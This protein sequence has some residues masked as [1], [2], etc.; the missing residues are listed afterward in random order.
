MAGNLLNIGK[1]GLFAAQA[2]LSTT[3]HNITNANVAGYSRQVVVQATSTMMQ[4]PHGFSGT[5]TKIASIKRYTDEFLNV[6]MRTA[7]A[8][9][10]SLDAFESQISQIDN[11]LADNTSGLSPTLQNFFNAVQDVTGNGASVP[12]RQSLLSAADTLASRFVALDGRLQEIREGVNQ[13]ITSNV[14]LINSYASQIAELN[15]K[16]GT[17]AATLDR[18]PNDLLD[19]RDQLVADLSSRSRPP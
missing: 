15:D 13:T 7:Q 6:Q 4:E 2:G 18:M 12:S 1:S 17:F 9:K 14:T 10:S 8:S 11:M 5:G 16:I 3:G 19:A